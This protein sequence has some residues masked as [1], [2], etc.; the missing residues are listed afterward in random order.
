M[1]F[2]LYNYAYGAITLSVLPP[3][4]LGVGFKAE[5]SGRVKLSSGLISVLLGILGNFILIE[6]NASGPNLKSL[7]VLTWT[8]LGS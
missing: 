7:T 5:A 4:A 2:V 3:N 8:E 1:T 6:I